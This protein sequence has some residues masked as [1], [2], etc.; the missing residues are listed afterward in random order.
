MT[1]TKKCIRCGK[2]A[3]IWTGYVQ[4]RNNEQV[5]AGWCSKACIEACR[6]LCGPFKKK[7]GEERYG[8]K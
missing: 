1:Q 6:G 2:E 5:L 3:K 8:V 7:Y 4:K